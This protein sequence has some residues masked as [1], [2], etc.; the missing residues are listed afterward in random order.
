[1]TVEIPFTNLPLADFQI[2]PR[3]PSLCDSY[4]RYSEC[5]K[6]VAHSLTS[7]NISASLLFSVCFS[8]VI[9]VLIPK[10][11]HVSCVCCC[12]LHNWIKYYVSQWNISIKSM[13]LYENKLSH[14]GRCGKGKAPVLLRSERDDRQCLERRWSNYR[15]VVRVSFQV[16]L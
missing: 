4:P 3:F 12:N 2:Y 7:R 15:R 8:R 16:C 1:M 6:Q 10:L 9:F 13:R 11:I 14:L 5:W